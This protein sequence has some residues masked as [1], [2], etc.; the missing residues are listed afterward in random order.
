[1]AR[2]L[3]TGRSMPGPALLAWWR[4]GRQAMLDVFRQLDP[5]TRIPWFGPAMSAVSF[6][7]ARLMETWAHGQDIVDTLGVQRQ[8][9][10]RLQHVAHI[11]VRARPFSYAVRGLTPPAEE[12]RV[13][14]R[15]PAGTIWT[16]GEAG[17]TNA[18]IGEAIDFCLVVTQR[19]HI[20]DTRLRL[21][22]PLAQEWMHLAQA[23][24]GPPG[25]GRQPGQFPRPL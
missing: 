16:W 22:G 19:R 5:K 13:E 7:T 21:V 2:Q 18:I 10:E 9:T 24:A 4:T 15:S 23:F 8:A 14:L 20:T 25:Q 17:A 6:A 3:E 12:V 1:M 11:G